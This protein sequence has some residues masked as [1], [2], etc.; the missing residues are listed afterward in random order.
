MLFKPWSPDKYLFICVLGQRI[1]PWSVMA[2]A[3]LWSHQLGVLWCLWQHHEVPRRWYIREDSS[4]LR[5]NLH[6]RRAGWDMS[7]GP[8]SAHWCDKGGAAVP[9]SPWN[10]QYVHKYTLKHWYNKHKLMLKTQFCFYNNIVS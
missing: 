8:S 9:D 7:A 5:Q 4:G 10:H 3:L 1:F 6:G 2:H